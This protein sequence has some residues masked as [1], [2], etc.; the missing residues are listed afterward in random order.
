MKGKTKTILTI[1]LAIAI[2]AVAAVGTVTFLKDN[3]RAA[4]ADA[5]EVTTLPVTGTDQTGT[6]NPGTPVTEPG[7]LGEE[8]AD[9][10]GPGNADAPDAI[11]PDVGTA[12]TGA[13][14]PATTGTGAGTAGTGTTTP[15]GEPAATTIETE[16]LA[17]TTLNWSN[18]E[19]NGNAGGRSVNYTKLKYT[20]N[21]IVVGAEELNETETGKADIGTTVTV[22][23]EEI[24][25]HCPTGYKPDE[26]NDP[27]VDITENEDDNVINIYYVKDEDQTQDTKYTVKHIVDGEAEPRDVEEFT[28]TAWINDDPAMIE[29]Q[30][31]SLDEKEY[32]GYKFDS[33]DTDKV[34]GDEVETGTVI[35]L[36]YVKDDSKTKEISYTVEYYKDDNETPT[37]TD[38]VTK[39]VWVNDTT[40]TVDVD[41][42]NVTDKYTGYSFEKTDPATI[43][44]EIE[45]DGVIKVY[46]VIDKYDY[47]VQYFYEGDNYEAEFNYV[48]DNSKTVNG[49]KEYNEEVASYEDKVITGYEFEKIEVLNSK[50]GDNE[51]PLVISTNPD[52]NIIKVYYK[53]LQID[54]T[55][56]YYYETEITDPRTYEID[57]SLTE[58][59]DT[60]KFGDKIEDYTPQ[61][62]TGFEFEKAETTNSETGDGA[63]PL[64]ISENAENNVI[65]VYYIKSTYAYSIEY[66]YN[67]EIDEEETITNL[68]AKFGTEISEYP[69][70]NRP[71]E[72][73]KFEK[74][75]T[76]NSATEDGAL[77]LVISENVENNVIKVYYGKPNVR[78]KSIGVDHAHVGEVIRYVITLENTGRVPGTID[79]KNELSVDVTFVAATGDVIPDENGIITWKNIT[80]D[81]GEDGEVILTID[82]RVNDNAI[83]KTLLDTVIVPNQENTVHE[84]IV[85]ELT[86]TVHEIKQ[87]ET[88]KD[89]VNVVLVMDLSTSMDNKIRHFTECTH[90]HRFVTHTYY[91]Y[92]WTEES[93]PEGCIKQTNGKW[94][95]YED[96]DQTRLQAA[97]AAAQGFINSIYNG[98]PNSQATVTVITFNDDATI[99]TFNGSNTTATKDNYGDL[100]T[101]VGTLATS[102]RGTNIRDALDK[103][104]TK[105]CGTNGL[106]TTYPDN[107]NV[108]IFLGDGEPTARYANNNTT[109]IRS[110]ARDIDSTTGS[111]AGAY[112]YAIGFGEEATDPE[113]DGYKILQ[114]ISSDGTVLTANDYTELAQIFTNI[115]AEL[116]DKIEGTEIGKLKFTV[117][118]TLIIDDDNPLRGL[119]DNGEEEPL[120]TCTSID[121]LAAYCIT[122]DEDERELSWD[123][124]AYNTGTNH[125]PHITSDNAILSYYIAR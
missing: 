20:V 4:A 87:G 110:R 7:N 42:I 74:V 18:I 40:L 78:V 100:V 76:T 72:G 1:A 62:K 84:T 55:V 83:G 111:G 77:P 113:G 49:S 33:I 22:T 118:N 116:E 9:V 101:K 104:Y 112:I 82:V 107:S 68:T 120:F 61:P 17:S 41:D 8:T 65:K 24:E 97:K 124:N 102:D 45:A 53:K 26:N 57:D 85:D 93:C 79:V 6:T 35:T 19:L 25:D 80:V 95:K 81:P 54:Y 114:V 60:A 5:E 51:L 3:G 121:E 47:Q 59:I 125:T 96:T 94:G 14:T 108:V 119:L 52:I 44:T 38:T 105:I 32:T 23:D 56:E 48:Q 63:L 16:R 46:Y 39:E 37:D 43:P 99:L 11:T 109:G 29:I 117:G 86:S 64:V 27:D 70:K 90:E 73:F 2:V 106:K 12:G 75:E 15:T 21:Y 92:T 69:D 58:T 34:A 67:G 30:E 89:S 103:T 98:H 91:G 115:E 31:G 50:T 122:Y 28:S 13:T 36:I 10:T 123:L 71:D 66:Y 88:G